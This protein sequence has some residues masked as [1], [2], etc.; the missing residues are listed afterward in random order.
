L[1]EFDYHFLNESDENSTYCTEEVQAS[2]QGS[3]CCLLWAVYDIVQ[4]LEQQVLPALGSVEATVGNYNTLFSCK[5]FWNF[6]TV[7][8][9]FVIGNYYPIMV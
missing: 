2:G 3:N 5:N 7:A 8:L 9:L 1:L 6:D 4:S